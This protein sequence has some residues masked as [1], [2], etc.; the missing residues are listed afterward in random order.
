MTEGPRDRANSFYTVVN[1]DK[2]VFALSKGITGQQI[3]KYLKL[4]YG[5]EQ[6]PAIF[7]DGKLV[8]G[9]S[10]GVSLMASKEFKDKIFEKK[11]RMKEENLVESKLQDEFWTM[12]YEKA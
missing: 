6:V 9:T 8:G 10:Q 11:F 3:L 4:K 7:F 1:V 12:F 5:Y 2:Y